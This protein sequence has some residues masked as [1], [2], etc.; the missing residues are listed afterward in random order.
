MIKNHNYDNN[1]R[2]WRVLLLVLCKIVRIPCPKKKSIKSISIIYFKASYGN[3]IFQ[4][5]THK[6]NFLI[7]CKKLDLKL[8]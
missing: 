8:I 3:S 2:L 5:G 1:I 6:L 4:N 7:I